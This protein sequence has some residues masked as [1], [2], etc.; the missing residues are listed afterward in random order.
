MNVTIENFIGIF[1]DAYTKEYCDSVIKYF[2]DMEKGGFTLNRQEQNNYVLKVFKDDTQLYGTDEVCASS[3][4][5]L[6]GVFNEI[7]WGKIYQT[8]ASKFDVLTRADP[9]TNYSFKI[10]KTGISEGY[11]M[12]HFESDNRANSNR[13]FA[14]ILYLNDVDEGGETEFLYYAKRVKPK[15][16][17]LLLWPAG[18]THAHRGNPPLSNTKYVITGWVVF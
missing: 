11:H 6:S 12:W 8:Y 4:G 10:Q 9:H 13:L 14:W 2:N 17:T 16:G 5:V 7:F 1:E 18:F 3:T 15:T